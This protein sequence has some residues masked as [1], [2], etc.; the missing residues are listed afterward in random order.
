MD[1]STTT[2]RVSARRPLRDSTNVASNTRC[3]CTVPWSWTV[4]EHASDT[5]GIECCDTLP[6]N[7][8]PRAQRKP[9]S[10]RAS[11]ETTRCGRGYPWVTTSYCVWC[12][13]NT[14]TRVLKCGGSRSSAH[15]PFRTRAHPASFTLKTQG[16]NPARLDTRVPFR[17]HTP[18]RRVPCIP[19]RITSANRRANTVLADTHNP[20]LRNRIAHTRTTYC[21]ARR[22]HWK[23]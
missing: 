18:A 20:A 23:T 21:K 8:S 13:I 2:T 15:W 10:S 9:Y 19:I 3:G 12:T 7:K 16:A 1:R 11:I 17:T 14:P 4:V 5:S 6:W 22:S